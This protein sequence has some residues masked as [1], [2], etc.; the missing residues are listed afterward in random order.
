[1]WRTSAPG[2]GRLHPAGAAL[3]QLHA[4]AGFQVLQALARGGQRQMLALRGPRDVAGFGDGEH[5]IERDE[6]EAHGRK[7][8]RGA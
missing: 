1:M 2:L 6:I 5:Q 4:Q 3:E 8:T 7:N